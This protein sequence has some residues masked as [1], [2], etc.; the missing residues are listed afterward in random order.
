VRR[1]SHVS[2][3]RNK[4]PDEPYTHTH[5][6]VVKAAALSFANGCWYGLPSRVN[7]LD[8]R[9]DC[10]TTLVLDVD[11]AAHDRTT[12]SCGVSDVLATLA[13]SG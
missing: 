11:A 8:K 2:G 5:M 13:R 9:A 7:A 6:A 10:T 12:A 3:V 1:P 4:I